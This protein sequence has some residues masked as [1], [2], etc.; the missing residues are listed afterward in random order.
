MELGT[1]AKRLILFRKPIQKQR[2]E[3]L[4]PVERSD[5]VSPDKTRLIH[6]R[7][8]HTG[9]H[10]TILRWNGFSEIERW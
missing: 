10:P 5:R 9:P 7:G 3:C 8:G 2:A 1:T 4:R 6:R